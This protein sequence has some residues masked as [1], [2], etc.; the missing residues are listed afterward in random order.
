M[1]LKGC[2]E[3]C[4]PIRWSFVG[5]MLLKVC[6]EGCMPLRGCFAG[7]MPSR[8]CLKW[9]M[10]LRG[11]FKSCMVFK[12]TASTMRMHVMWVCSGVNFL[13]QI[14]ATLVDLKNRCHLLVI[15]L[16]FLLVW[17]N[18]E[19]YF[20][21]GTLKKILNIRGSGPVTV[22]RESC[23]TGIA[24]LKGHR[25]TSINLVEEWKNARRCPL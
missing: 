13:F 17:T 15:V 11:C 24:I 3:G 22:K 10:P 12:K 8:R 9:C 1:A 16:F 20:Q 7:C 23:S 25:P 19:T 2:F 6:F 14:W 18:T 4:M 5:C 21:V